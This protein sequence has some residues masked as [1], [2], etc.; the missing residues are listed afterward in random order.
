MVLDENTVKAATTLIHEVGMP[1]LA[2]AYFA[3]KD[4]KFTKELVEQLTKL[5]E[6]IH[7][8]EG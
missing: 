4:Y 2:C 7:H 3:Y 5:N 6:R 8:T 1:A